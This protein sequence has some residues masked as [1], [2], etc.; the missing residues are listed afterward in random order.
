MSNTLRLECFYNWSGLC[1]S[2]PVL[3]SGV[4][5]DEGAVLF[6]PLLVQGTMKGSV[7]RL[8]KAGEGWRSKNLRTTKEIRPS[9]SPYICTPR[10]RLLISGY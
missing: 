7:L 3:R 4:A 1:G 6:K 2:K 10:D 8:K 9:Q 5:G